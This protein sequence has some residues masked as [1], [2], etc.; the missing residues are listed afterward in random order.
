MHISIINFV[1]DINFIKFMFNEGIYCSE[2][3]YSDQNILEHHISTI[4]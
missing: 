4:Y 3:V 2:V 1:L